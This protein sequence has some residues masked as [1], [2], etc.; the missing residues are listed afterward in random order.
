[1]TKHIVRS[2]AIAA[3]IVALTPLGSLRAET[4]SAPVTIPY[5]F[6]VQ[7]TKLPAGEYRVEQPMGTEYAMLVNMKTGDRVYVMRPK[8]MRKDGKTRL[9]IAHTDAGAK[10]KIS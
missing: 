10:L 2:V 7:N 9:I 5:E 1:M 8:P 3:G 6:Q 4:K